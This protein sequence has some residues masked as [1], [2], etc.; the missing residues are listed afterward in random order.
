VETTTETMA[1]T[2]TCNVIVD[3]GQ[4]GGTGQD[5]WREEDVRRSSGEEQGQSTR[6][7]VGACYIYSMSRG[8]GCAAN[9]TASMEVALVR[10]KAERQ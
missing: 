5:C 1:T 4:D 7:F 9:N 2:T 3:S 8:T 6:A 10:M